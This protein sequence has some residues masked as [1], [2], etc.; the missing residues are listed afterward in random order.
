MHQCLSYFLFRKL[1]KI[2]SWIKWIHFSSFKLV[3]FVELFVELLYLVYSLSIYLTF[4][5]HFI[6]LFFLNVFINNYLSWIP[7]EHHMLFSIWL[8]ILLKRHNSNFLWKT[9]SHFL[10]FFFDIF[11]CHV[12]CLLRNRLGTTITFDIPEINFLIRLMKHCKHLDTS[13]IIF[14]PAFCTLTKVVE[15]LTTDKNYP[16]ISFIERLIY[17]LTI[18]HT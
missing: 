12:V 2:A 10:C 3:S 7:Y 1:R 6:T 8:S 13:E 11:H 5:Y 18:S 4:L 9:Q 17:H 16:N 14:V 15:L